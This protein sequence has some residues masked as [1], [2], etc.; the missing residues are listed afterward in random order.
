MS[1]KL[2]RTYWKI[3][4]LTKRHRIIQGGMSSSKTYSIMIHLL[5]EAHEHAGYVIT[6]VTS[7]Y[8][9][10]KDGTIQDFKNICESTGVDFETYFNKSEKNFNYHNGSV[11]QFRNLDSIDHHKGKGARRDILFVNEANRCGYT[12][13][14]HLIT[15]TDKYIIYDYNPDIEFYIHDFMKE[16]KEDVDFLI[17]TYKDNSQIPLGELNEI[18][19]RIKSSKLPG[20][21]DQLKNWVRIYA[22]GEIGTYSDRQIYSYQFCDKI[23][24][25]ARK[26][27]AGMDFGSSPDPTILVDLYI[28]GANLYADEI[29]CENNLLAEKITGAERM[30]VVDKMD[31][32]GYNKGQLIVGDT[33]GKLSILDMRKHGYNV[34]AVKKNIPV[35]D[36]IVKVNSYNLFI[37]KRSINIK[38][39]IESWHRK[40]DANGKIIPE[41]DGHE[42]DGLA[43]IR[44][45]IMF[46]YDN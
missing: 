4:A 6:V 41:P 13:L 17:V 32:V 39:G 24:D 22:Y 29:F 26:I 11:I 2:T 40:V 45:G 46:Y 21:S 1:V 30:S 10:L 38:K 33:S 20:A 16:N 25:T 15:R 8:P 34:I 7:T 23:P 44:Y 19:K 27:N 12:S 18:K 42:P 31:E 43:A 14:E 35:I 36:G 9:L 3:L 37:T 5:R 28:E